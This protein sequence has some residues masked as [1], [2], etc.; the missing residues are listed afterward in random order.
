[1]SNKKYLIQLALV[2]LL[3]FFSAAALFFFQ[4]ASEKKGENSWGSET[5][6]IRI[7]ENVFQAEIADTPFKRSRGLSGRKNLCEDCA[8]LFLFSESGKFSFWMKDM[9]FDLDI[10]WIAR[11]E[12]AHIAKNVSRIK[13]F[14][15]I[16]PRIEA[17]KV[18]E[19]NAGLADSLD[20][21][22]GDKMEFFDPSN[23]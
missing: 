7:G 5:K 16:N 11:N 18:L 15:R 19:I 10:I 9:E 14:E 13:E 1:M 6:E 3:S 21:K 8:M 22:V 12:I 23:K 4:D 20:I 17:D 2:G